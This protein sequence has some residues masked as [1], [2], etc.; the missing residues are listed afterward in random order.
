MAGRI[1]DQLKARYG[2]ASV[3][4]DI[5]N[6]P[7]GIDFRDHIHA[8]LDQADVLIV[9]VGPKWLGTRRNA[10]NR[11]MEEHDPVRPGGMAGVVGH[12]DDGAA[13]GAALAQQAEHRLAGQRVERAGRLIGEQHRPAAGRWPSPPAA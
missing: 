9:V 6:I 13:G 1:C 8:A 4:M 2:D 12:Q 11:I 3:Y 7:L 10:N 5:D